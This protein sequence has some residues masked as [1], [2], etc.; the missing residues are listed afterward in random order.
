MFTFI[1][2]LV[3]DPVASFSRI[4]IILI[5]SSSRARHETRLP[6]SLEDVPCYRRETEE[7]LTGGP[8]VIKQTRTERIDADFCLDLC[9]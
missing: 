3:W 9:E 2:W 6:P 5:I 8:S 1:Q 7:S 4:I